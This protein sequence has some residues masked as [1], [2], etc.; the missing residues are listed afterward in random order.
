V[1][2]RDRSHFVKHHSDSSKKFSESDI[3]NMFEF[4]IDN[5][6][7]MFGGRVFNRESAYLLSPTCSFHTTSRVASV[8]VALKPVLTPD[9]IHVNNWERGFVKH[10]A[11]PAI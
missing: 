11:D 9:S 5:I 10:L 7:V 1:L 8:T 4:L 3:F 6:F 2:E